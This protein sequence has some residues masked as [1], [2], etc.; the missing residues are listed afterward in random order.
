[1]ERDKSFQPLK[2][3]LHFLSALAK[4][5]PNELMFLYL[6]VITGAVKAVFVKNEPATQLLIYYVKGV[7]GSPSRNS[8]MSRRRLIHNMKGSQFGILLSH[9]E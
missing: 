2:K 9:N 6:R 3:Q 5:I 7:H 4:P 1:M 8:C